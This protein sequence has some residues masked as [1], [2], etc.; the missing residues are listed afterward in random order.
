MSRSSEFVNMVTGN[1]GKG[2]ALGSDARR[3]KGES[4]LAGFSIDDFSIPN[5]PAAAPAAAPPPAAGALPVADPTTVEAS[6]GFAENGDPESVAKLLKVDS[7]QG[8][9]DTEPEDFGTPA[10]DR[11]VKSQKDIPV[12][13]VVDWE[14]AKKAKADA[15][16]RAGMADRAANIDQEFADLKQRKFQDYATR[17]LQVL[18]SDPAKAAKMLSMASQFTADGT[19]SQFL[20]TPGGQLME[21]EIDEMTGQPLGKGTPIDKEAL[22]KFVLM[23]SDPQKFLYSQMDRDWKSER[24]R[25]QDEQWQK[26]YQKDLDQFAEKAKQWAAGMDF[27]YDELDQRRAIEAGKLAAKKAEES[28]YTQQQWDKKVESLND[29]LTAIG[30]P[31]KFRNEF[32]EE[33]QFK[34][35]EQTGTPQMP[36]MLKL[37]TGAESFMGGNGHNQTMSPQTATDLF[38]LTSDPA[39]ADKLKSRMDT[40]K[41]S[42]KPIIKGKDGVWYYLPGQGQA[43]PTPIQ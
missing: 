3:R 23:N 39:Q 40:D 25:E 34:I 8:A 38:L 14:A 7:E 41:K 15:Y 5:E 32:G 33:Y 17:A 29:Y 6:V 22:S 26:G 11:A 9:I 18:E 27:K 20:P 2:Y 13:N 21:M 24:A 31:M 43:A 35:D 1:F 37:R 28:G 16:V 36:D 30:D 10:L 42:G 12:V 19:T 4:D